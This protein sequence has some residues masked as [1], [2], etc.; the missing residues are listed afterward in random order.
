MR[1]KNALPARNPSSSGEFRRLWLAGL[2]AAALAER[3]GR[4][5]FAQL[6]AEG[7]RIR[8]ESGG[9]ARTLAQRLRGELSARRL[10]LGRRAEAAAERLGGMVEDL[11]SSLIERLG[12]PSRRE[13]RELS[14][15]I[16]ELR[17]RLAGLAR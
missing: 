6:V 10:T 3:Q 9:I 2:G 13:I 16:A 5:L 15:R 7:R 11:S 8:A 4:R 12:I 14:A 1:S 17:H